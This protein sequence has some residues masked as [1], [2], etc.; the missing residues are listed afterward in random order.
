MVAPRIQMKPSQQKIVERGDRSGY[1]SAS[2]AEDLPVEDPEEGHPRNTELQLPERRREDRKVRLRKRMLVQRP[3]TRD[4]EAPDE[5]PA[6]NPK[7]GVAVHRL[8]EGADSSGA[9]VCGEKRTERCAVDMVEGEPSD[10]PVEG[11]QPLLRV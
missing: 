2:V 1:R 11:P 9:Q 8:E 6:R 10:D 5:V 7:Q 3:E 4:P